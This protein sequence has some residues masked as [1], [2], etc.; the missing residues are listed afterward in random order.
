MCDQGSERGQST[1]EGN[2]K[3][4]ELELEL[5]LIVVVGVIVI[6]IV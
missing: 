3:A 4:M 5:E 6:V 1:H 2:M